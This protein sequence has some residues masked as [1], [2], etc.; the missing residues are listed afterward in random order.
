MPL[1]MKVSVIVVTRNTRE[2]TLNCLQQLE[3][4]IR[5]DRHEIVVVDNASSDGTAAA[6]AARYPKV[7]L[8]REPRNMGFARASNDGVRESSGEL[9]LFLNSDTLA[10]A[11]AVEGLAN[12]L[13]EE[14]ALGAVAPQLMYPDGRLQETAGYAP[15]PIREFSSSARKAARARVEA[16]VQRVAN[17]AG[18]GYLSGAALMVRREAFAAIGGF[19]DSFFFYYE[20]A[21]LCT[22]LAARG[23]AIRI[24]P[25]V[26]VVHLR[27]GST[28]QAPGPVIEMTRSRYQYLRKHYGLAR[29]LVAGG[30]GFL[31][32]L[33][34]AV[35][36]TLATLLTAGCWPTAR[37][38]AVLHS[39]LCLWF[40]LLTPRRESWVYRT[41]FGDW[42]R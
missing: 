22:Q 30:L 36:N 12:A 21:D 19:D 5:S 14:P 39:R 35:L 17:L 28:T 3:D 40:L 1:A 2:M 11:R 38:K 25:E 31:I 32:T 42:Q 4:S 24:V 27:R 33:R 6:I 9:L 26:T 23:W 10:S 15:S 7:T 41:L 29:A 20:D 34:R 16:A 37:R 13:R 8:L 18:V